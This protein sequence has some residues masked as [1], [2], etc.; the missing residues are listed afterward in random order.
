M[1]TPMGDE[2]AAD[3]YAE[4]ANQGFDPARVVRPGP[5]GDSIP[6]RFPT[7]MLD[8]VRVA[9]DREGVTVSEWVRRAVGAMLAQHREPEE[10]AAAI[11]REL[12]RL[13]RKL[14]RSA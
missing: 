14:R 2:N 4:P 7:G 1:S 11:A 9:A 6:V 13:A 10:G 3:F 5:L 12:E 8:E